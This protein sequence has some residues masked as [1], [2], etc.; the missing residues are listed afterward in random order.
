MYM[1][2]FMNIRTVIINNIIFLLKVK[3]YNIQIQNYGQ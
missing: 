3:L 2:D 1:I